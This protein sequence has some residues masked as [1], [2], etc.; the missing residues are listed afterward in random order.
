MNQLADLIGGEKTYIPARPEARDTLGDISRAKELLQWSPT[1]T[2]E[3]GIAE[4]KNE[5]QIS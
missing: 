2:L 3:E 5:L 4:L 1:V